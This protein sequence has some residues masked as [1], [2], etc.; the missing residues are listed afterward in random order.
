MME[1]QISIYTDGSCT[2]SGVG[3]WAASLYFADGTIHLYGNEMNTTNNRMEMTA[4]IKALEYLQFPCI[5]HLYADSQYVLNG[6]DSYIKVW[7]QN[8][9]V[10][11]KKTPVQNK[12]LWEQIQYQMT[13]HTIHC[14]WVRGHAGIPQ[15]EIVDGLA[16]S[17]SKKI[18]TL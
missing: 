8:A 10:T 1:Y 9:W 5:V 18:N 12:D 15:N 2:S 17:M 11:C 16:Q 4:V 3:G 6:I 14:H 13:R 7:E